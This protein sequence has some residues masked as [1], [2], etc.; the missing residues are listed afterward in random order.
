MSIRQ[1]LYPT[2]PVKPLRLGLH[3]FHH[4]AD[5]PA[6]LRQVF[7]SGRI[8]LPGLRQDPMAHAISGIIVG[9]VGGICPP[10]YALLTEPLLNLLPAGI[11]QKADDHPLPGPHALHPRQMSAAKQMQQQCLR[12]VFPVMGHGDL[13]AAP[14]F[15][16]LGKRLITG[17]PPGLFQ[18]QSFP[19]GPLRHCAVYLSERNAPRLTKLTAKGSVF[20]RLLPPDAVLHMHRTER[21][22]HS[23]RKCLQCQQQADRISAAGQAHHNAVAR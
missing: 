8:D 6:G 1:P 10:E 18:R 17:L 23:H 5:G 16:H 3:I 7:C 19:S 20:Q 9:E 12:L 2:L 4:F 21:Q 14:C 11:Q 13:R 22:R 15:Q